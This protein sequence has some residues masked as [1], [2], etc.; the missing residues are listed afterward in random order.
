MA[1]ATALLLGATGLIGGHCLNLLLAADN[2][3][4]VVT[5]GRKSVDL[6]HPKLTQHIV[7]LGQPETYA[8]LLRPHT[9]VFCCLG[10]TIK[11]AGSEAAFRR[12]DYEYPLNVARLAAQWEDTHFLLVSALGA[13]AQSHVFYP[14]V[15]GELEE[16]LQELPFAGVHILRPSLLLGARGEFRLGERIAE[17]AALPFS[18]VLLGPLRK[19]RPIQARVVASALVRVAREGRAGVETL[20]SDQIVEKDSV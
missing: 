11:T 6:E 7:D 17:Y 9:D 3:A 12:V 15:K 1:T 10:T 18:L 14:R 2:Y 13:N 19:Y 4:R 8:H 5:L 16:A 20:E